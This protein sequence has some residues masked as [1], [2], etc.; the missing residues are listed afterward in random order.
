MFTV[1]H[2]VLAAV[3]IAIPLASPVSA[4]T[5]TR[6]VSYADLDLTSHAG[7]NTL[8]LRVNSAVDQVCGSVSGVRSMVE[9]HD[10]KSCREDTLAKTRPQIAQATF[11]AQ[12]GLASIEDGSGTEVAI[13]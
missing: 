1:R 2:Y 7:R 11:R 5:Q 12:Q 6:R 8:R 4:E 13:R 3:A 10:I 9:L